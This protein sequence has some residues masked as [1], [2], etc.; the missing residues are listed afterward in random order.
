MFEYV[1]RET[2]PGWLTEKREHNRERER[3]RESEQGGKRESVT[4][5]VRHFFRLSIV[6][7]Y[8][9]ILKHH[10]FFS[11]KGNAMGQWPSLWPT[12]F[13]FQHHYTFIRA[14]TL[15]K[16]AERRTGRERQR[17]REKEREREGLRGPTKKRS[18]EGKKRREREKRGIKRGRRLWYETCLIQSEWQWRACTRICV[19]IC[20]CEWQRH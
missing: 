20:P 1:E 7:L 15:R 19:C 17:E 4:E 9:L 2:E 13:E 14:A 11:E 8:R 10:L 12:L 3:E 5:W 16:T 18:K 6:S